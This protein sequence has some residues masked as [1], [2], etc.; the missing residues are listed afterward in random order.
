MTFVCCDTC[1]HFVNICVCGSTVFVIYSVCDVGLLVILFPLNKKVQYKGH[2]VLCMTIFISLVANHQRP[3]VK[4]AIN[5]VI[6][7]CHFNFP[8]ACMYGF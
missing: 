8:Q 2:S 6:A 7:H 3:Q 4:W 5:L 1:L